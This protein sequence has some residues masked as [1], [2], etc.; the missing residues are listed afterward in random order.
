VP[1]LELSRRVFLKL[2][3]VFSG[4]VAALPFAS[5]GGY[6]SF[7]QEIKAEKKKIANLSEIM[8]NSALYFQWPTDS[9]R[10]MS[11]LIA[12]DSM[13]L[14]AYNAACTHLGCQ[15][16]YEPGL[17]LITCPCHGSIFDPASGRVMQGP[18]L[19]SLTPIKLEVDQDEIYVAGL[20]ED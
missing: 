12:D 7:R 9:P 20:V 8:P 15:V 3:L 18:A 1:P 16:D 6:L 19:S 5:Y 10:D 14:F 4:I 17:H 11:I 2:F 13:K